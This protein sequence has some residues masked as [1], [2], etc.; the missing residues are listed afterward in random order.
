MKTIELTQGKVAIVDDSDFERVNQFK[1]TAQKIV[2][3]SRNKYYAK[4]TIWH[5]WRAGKQ[6]VVLL[7]RFILNAPAGTQVDH[8][9]G[10]S[11]DCQR[12]NLRLA[13]SKQNNANRSILRKRE[14]RFKGVNSTPAGNF[15]AVIS[16]NGRARHLGTFASAE[17]AAAAYDKKAKELFG[18][19]A[20]LNFPELIN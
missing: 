5:D 1:W 9:N 4:R 15:S 11:L 3:R 2:H 18:E 17:I 7:H 14:I 6:E 12:R 10:D 8:R 20:R 16:I 13:T 19:F